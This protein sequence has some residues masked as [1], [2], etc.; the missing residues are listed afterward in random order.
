LAD[1]LRPAGLGLVLGLAGGMAAAKMIRDLLYGVKPLDA[2]V[3]VGVAVIL[4][5][6]A[7]GACGLPAWRA[8]RLN[9]VDALRM[10]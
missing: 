1:G 10:E 7:I 3:F 5:A 9:P 2:S 8:S 4:L 6:V